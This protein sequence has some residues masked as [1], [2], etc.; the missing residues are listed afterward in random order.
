MNSQSI[1]F[2]GLALFFVSLVFFLIK[3]LPL[4]IVAAILYYFS[5]NFNR[6]RKEKT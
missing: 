6:K 5:G 2:A 4:V 3:V 1:I